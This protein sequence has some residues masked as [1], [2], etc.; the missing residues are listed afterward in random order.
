MAGKLDGEPV[1]VIGEAKLN[2]PSKVND[3]LSQLA[4][5][6]SRWGELCYKSQCQGED[7]VGDDGEPMMVSSQDVDDI[8]KLRVAEFAD[9]KVMYALGGACIPPHTLKRIQHHMRTFGQSRWLKVDMAQG[10]AQVCGV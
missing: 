5:N 1:I 10:V 3:A 2:M 8:R 7:G 9:H 6:A 4:N